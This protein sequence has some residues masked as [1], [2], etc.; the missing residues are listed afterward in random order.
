MP[1]RIEDRYV[2]KR[3]LNGACVIDRICQ[4]C[5]R[6]Y[7]GERNT[8]PPCCN[9]ALR[10]N[11]KF[12]A[13]YHRNY[14]HKRY[15]KSAILHGKG[16]MTK[17]GQLAQ[18][19]NAAWLQQK[20]RIRNELLAITLAKLDPDENTIEEIEQAGVKLQE[21]LI[22]SNHGLTQIFTDKMDMDP[23]SQ[24]GMTYGR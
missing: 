4:K 3:Y 9:E 16:K 5:G 14:Y 20:N 1:R 18:L 2:Y 19:R 13:E 22:E 11:G 23:G 10:K 6:K 7:I 12:S 17:K 21:F 15:S 24:S 8:C